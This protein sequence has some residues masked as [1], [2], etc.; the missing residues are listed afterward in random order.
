MARAKQLQSTDKAYIEAL[1]NLPV[2][3]VIFDNNKVY[4]LNKRAIE[5]LKFQKNKLPDLKKLKLWSFVMPEYHKSSKA[6]NLKI[7]KGQ[8]FPPI[9]LKIR[10]TKGTII[11]VEAKSN[12]I[13]FNGVKVIQSTFHEISARKRKHEEL[14][15]SNQVLD[16]V[17]KN[18]TDIIY[19]YDFFPKERYVYVSDSI[20][21]VLGYSPSSFYNDNEFYKKIVHPGDLKKIHQSK[22][23]QAADQ[24]KETNTLARYIRKDGSYVWIEIDYSLI[25]D[26]TGKVISILGICRNV[27]ALKQKE[28]ELNQKWNNYYELL[29]ESPIA[30]FIHRDGNCLM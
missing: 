9:E 19:K 29:N 20:K 5:I 14:V 11:D 12:A 2:A 21:T 15:E 13:I 28:E 18:N 26:K 1:E 23:K 4:Y 7:L 3:L 6:V 30:F 10:D 25:K 24:R 27:S 17:G 16:L 22:K 8:E